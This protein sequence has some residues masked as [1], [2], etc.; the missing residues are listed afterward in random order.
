MAKTNKV[1]MNKS[2]YYAAVAKNSG[3]KVADVVK[4]HDS[5]V[6]TI[7]Q[8]TSDLVAKDQDPDTNYIVKTP[9]GGMGTRFLP[10]DKDR[11]NG[12]TGKRYDIDARQGIV[13][14]PSTKL[15][16]LVNAK[17]DYGINKAKAAASAPKKSA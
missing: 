6:E 12:A 10:A 16:V 15:K 9:F 17:M 14:A 8:T 7:F 5:A 13:F 4:V 2:E 1:I 11:L 3:M